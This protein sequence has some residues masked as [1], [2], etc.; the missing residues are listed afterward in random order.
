MSA[1]EW[2]SLDVGGLPTGTVTLLLADVEGSTRLWQTQPEVMTEAV[3]QLDRVLADVVQRHQGV[4]PVEQGEGD[5]FVVAFARASDALGCAVDLQRAALA[6][7]RLRIGVHTGEIQLRDEGNYIGPTINRT[8]RLRDLAHG[9]QTVLSGATEAMVLDCLPDGA[10]LVDRGTHPLRDLPRPERVVQLCH[11]DLCNEFPPLRAGSAERR[12]PTQLT[13][14]IGRRAERDE[15]GQLLADHRFVTLTG[16]GGVGKTR[17]ALE[18]A[19]DRGSDF[20]DGVWCIDLAPVT[21]PRLVPVTAARTMGLPDQAG[22]SPEDILSAFCG[23]RRMLLLLDNCEHLLDSCGHLVA[24]LLADCPNLTILSTSREP[25]GVAGELTWRVPSLSLKTEAVDLFADRAGRALPGFRL[26]DANVDAVIEICA[27]LDGMPLAIELA[28]ARVRA[29]TL[30]QIKDSLHD[31]FRLLTGGARTAVRRQQTLRASVEW[32]H[33]L[34]TDAERVL[35]RRLSVFMGSFDLGAGTAVGGSSEVERFQLLDQISLLVDKSLVVAEDHRGVMRY[36]LLETVRQYAL[37]KLGE[38]GEADDVRTRH[39]DF[40]TVTAASYDVSDAASRVRLMDWAETEMD[41]L[42]AAYTWSLEL[43]EPDSALRLVSS[44]HDLWFRRGRQREGIAAF[45]QV[46]DDNSCRDTVAPQVWTRAV[47]DHAI[48]AASIA[49]PAG[50]DRAE[51]AL[52]IARTLDSPELLAWTLTACGMLTFYDGALA[53]SRFAEGAR[54]SEEAGCGWLTCQI[55]MME[56]IARIFA[57]D[58]ARAVDVAEKARVVADTVGDDYF[59]QQSRVWSGVGMFQ[60]GRLAA[61]EETLRLLD[62]DVAAIDEPPITRIFRLVGHGS[63]AA[64]SG[65]VDEA[66][67]RGC[68]AVLAAE[69]AGGIYGDTVYVVEAYAALVEGDAQRARKACEDA[70]RHTIPLREPF[71]RCTNPF[72][73]ALL[74]CGD[75]AAARRWADEA[76]AVVP[77]IFVS[78]ALTVRAL[79]AL[80]E[81]RVRE[82]ENDVLAALASVAATGPHMRVPDILECLARIHAADNVHDRAVRLLGAAAT[83]REDTGA[84]RFGVYQRDHAAAVAACRVGLGDNAFQTLW[85][86]GAGLTPGQAIAYALRGRGERKRPSS[87]W[88]SLTPTEI[89]VVR[90]VKEGLGNKDIAARLF[91]SHRT[92]QT[93]LTH[94]Y[95]KL[96]LTS[97][98]QLAQEAARRG[99]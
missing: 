34:L 80:A 18:V 85:A 37:E 26:D 56:A 69:A 23:R 57:G 4:R 21:D 8:A 49:L 16:A 45:E 51:E 50:A 65:R 54:V 31:R 55:Q 3:A 24:R 1:V 72:A 33:N 48:L 29:L 7:L 94:V 42:R 47:A 44:V 43:A 68:A 96:G 41:N 67:A 97:R 95:S 99:D 84:V 20:P 28:A 61:A 35:F 52:A 62:A 40:Y 6:P 10:W 19:A 36:R 70:W 2:G 77:G 74:A 17:I 73:E 78:I 66:Y 87:G 91:I 81:N 86:E 90:L 75:P 11:P 38:S 46:L 9:G 13:S 58:P 32:S 22:R 53:D 76:V 25:I 88:E 59:S 79:V 63:V 98:V 93:H 60:T 15:V 30:S 39:R 71:A 12:L 5:S 83:V 82:A 92:V 64:Y 89:D 14:F 27:R